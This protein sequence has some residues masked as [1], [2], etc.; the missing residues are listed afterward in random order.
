MERTTQLLAKERR[1]V[2]IL[3]C[4]SLLAWETLS[5]CGPS[6]SDT[7]QVVRRA[8]V[9]VARV[10]QRTVPRTLK[11]IGSVES[12]HV[13]RVM[14][15]VD[16]QVAAVHFREGERVEQ[17]QLLFT[18]DQRPFENLLQ[19]RE[20]ALRRDQAQLV[21]ARAEA[22]RRAALFE[23]GLISAEENEEAQTRVATLEA[24]VQAD[25][26][27]VADARLQLEYCSIRS[28]VAG[29]TSQILVHP[30]NIVRKNETVLTIV[31]Q[32][33]PVRVAFQI[34]EQDLPDVRDQARQR[35]LAVRASP[36][37]DGAAVTTGELEFIDNTVQRSTGTVLLK[38]LFANPAEELWP[39]QFVPVELVVSEVPNALV[40]PRV[41]LQRGQQGPFVFR[42]DGED[43]VR[44]APVDIAF[45][46]DDQVVVRSGLETGQW[47]VTEGQFRL[48]D[49]ALV[50]VR[51]RTPADA[52]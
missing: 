43:L 14:P 15:Q 12:V 13:V 36:S 46:T 45:D 50:E 19:Q 39:G 8:P 7:P 42:L 3:G 48:T 30:G 16:G 27:A 28:P 41:A 11:A 23:Q 34:R 51:A 35:R 32:M 37:A 31:Q 25:R 29:R 52:R 44:A 6:Q 21:T 4:V 1:A 24:T 26:A 2:L 5:G 47:V 22:R 17:G 10:E 20:G 9:S 40:I 33:A 38:G 18:L 49:G